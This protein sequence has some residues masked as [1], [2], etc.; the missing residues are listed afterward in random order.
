MNIII[1]TVIFAAVS[2]FRGIEDIR[3]Y[4][5]GLYLETGANGARLVG[6]DGHQLAVAKLDGEYPES[7]IILPGSLVA[8]VKS[9]AKGPQ[10]VTLEFNDG[11]Q[12]YV[13]QG[14]VEGI[15]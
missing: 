2:I 3:Y 12:Q 13:K 11:H 9:R 5:N 10:Q 15:S 14:N 1:N 8:S 4:L 6:C 7:S